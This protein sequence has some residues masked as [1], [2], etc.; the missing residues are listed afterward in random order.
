M[1]SPARTLSLLVAITLLVSGG[2]LAGMDIARL[3]DYETTTGTVETKQIEQVPNESAAPAVTVFRE[4][5]DQL[6]APNVTYTYT[7]GGERY[8]GENVAAGTQI[9]RD[10]RNTTVATVTAISP[11][12]TTVYYDSDNPGDAHLLPRFD[13]FPAGFLL[14]CGF[15]IMADTLTPRLRFIRLF[16]TWIPVQSLERLPGVAAHEPVG[17][18]DNPTKI[19]ESKQ[20]WAGTDPAPFQGDTAF[21]VWLFAFL[22]ITDTLVAYYLLSSPP[23]DTWA[24]ATALM[25]LSGFATLVF[26]HFND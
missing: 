10:S 15:L 23:Y 4:D 22:C 5:S 26:R 21:A 7:V 12:P 16:S 17:N 6:Y 18:A 25:A 13:Y 24:A 20:T 1:M 8:T 3:A 11:G 2:V 14:L 9:V 19:L